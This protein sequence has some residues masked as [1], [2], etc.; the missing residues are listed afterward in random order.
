MDSTAAVLPMV[1]A[2]QEERADGTCGSI[3]MGIVLL[4][5]G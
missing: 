1:T 4:V 5:L 3:V 2:V